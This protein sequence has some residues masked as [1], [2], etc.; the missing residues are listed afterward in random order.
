MARLRTTVQARRRHAALFALL[1]T[2][3]GVFVLVPSATAVHDL[4]LFELDGN[5]VGGVPGGPNDWNNINPPAN[6]T[7]AIATTFITDPFN[8]STDSILSGGSTKDDLNLNGGPGSGWLCKRG[9]AVDKNDIE[10]A[11]AA[12]YEDANG[13]VILY[14]GADKYSV[15]GDA[16][17]GFWFF[18]N[19]VACNPTSAQNTAFTGTHSVGDLLILSDFTNGGNVSTIRAFEWVGSGGNVNGTLQTVGTPGQDCDTVGTGDNLCAQ[20]NPVGNETTGGWTYQQKPNLVGAPP[21]ADA[22]NYPKGA[23]YEGGV[24]LSELLGEDVSCFSSFM[25]ETRQSQS[26]DSVLEDF[27]L[28]LF[29]TCRAEVETTPSST[30]IVLGE[31]I[32]DSAEITGFGIGAP[33]P[34]GTVNFFVCGP[35]EAGELCTTG[36]TAIGSVDLSGNTDNPVTVESDAF[37]PDAVGRYCFRAE[38]VDDPNYDEGA[39]DSRESECFTVTDTTETA[40]LQNWTPNDSAT[41]TSAGDSNLDGMVRFQLYSDGACGANG[42]TALY[43]EDVDVPSGTAS[44]HTVE[45]TNGD[46]D[47]ATG[48]ASDEVFDASDSPVNVSWRVTFASDDTSVAGSTASCETSTGLIIDD[49]NEPPT[50]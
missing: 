46:G 31:S 1:V 6:T 8:T 15:S 14:F 9:G 48:L 47:P 35:L 21:K 39:V 3:V 29:D 41:I 12:A 2:L 34:T 10:H 23:F 11:F 45:T 7:T 24:N 37:T 42:G 30:S 28:G 50:P 36:G 20:V 19:P 44:P 25:A 5:A 33:P 4:G 43:Q 13:D 17:I 27:A 22:G 49:D 18:K 32:T 26:V 40:T 16:Q 38:L